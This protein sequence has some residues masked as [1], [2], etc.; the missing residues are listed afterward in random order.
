M[1]V[2]AILV[3]IVLFVS[4]TAAFWS[5]RVVTS[6]AV[7]ENVQPQIQINLNI[8]LVDLQCDYVSLDVWDALGTNRQNVTKHID[9]WQLDEQGVRRVFS[10]RNRDG[11]ALTHEEHSKTLEQMHAEDGVHAVVLTKE[12]Y[13]E[14]MSEHDLAFVDLYAPWYV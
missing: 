7:D 14:F 5:S 8:T 9:K 6:I 11:R 12:N 13:E 1:S 3:M 10:G 2:C 4:E